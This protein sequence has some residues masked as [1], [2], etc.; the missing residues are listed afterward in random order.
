ML[1]FDDVPFLVALSKGSEML[2]VC[3]HYSEAIQDYPAKQLQGC[4]NPW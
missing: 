1:S 3:N 4:L 2:T